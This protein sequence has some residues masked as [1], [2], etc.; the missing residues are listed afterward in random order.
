MLTREQLDHWSKRR[1]FWV[2]LNAASLAMFVT[3]YRKF[4]FLDP[5]L[6]HEA[7]ASADP[8]ENLMGSTA[9][10]AFGLS[11]F[12]SVFSAV[13]SLFGRNVK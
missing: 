1:F 3:L 8:L 11:A 5:S 6:I 7:T 4:G 2:V 13:I 10:M 9:I 12:L